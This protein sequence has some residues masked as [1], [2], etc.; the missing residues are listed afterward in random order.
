MNILYSD[1][2]ALN[3]RQFHVKAWQLIP[4]DSFEWG[5]ARTF[6]VGDTVQVISPLSPDY[7]KEGE[8]C[9][10]TDSSIKVIEHRSK[11]TVCLSFGHWLLELTRLQFAVP[12][13]FLHIYQYAT[14]PA[15]DG[16]YGSYDRC[17]ELVNTWIFVAG[18][19]PK[20]SLYGRIREAIGNHKVRIE[21]RS[22]ARLVDIHIDYLYSP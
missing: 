6:L 12:P 15:P 1:D 2:M 22:G 9:N 3:M 18:N 14:M 7:G 20:K 8:V 19:H 21:V 16:M 13:W 4:H 10:V 5:F 17:K 11:T